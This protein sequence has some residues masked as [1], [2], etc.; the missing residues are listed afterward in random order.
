MTKQFSKI[1]IPYY[2]T[3]NNELGFL[4]SHIFDRF[5]AVFLILIILQGVFW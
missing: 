2:T 5:G 1:V 3:P 4:L